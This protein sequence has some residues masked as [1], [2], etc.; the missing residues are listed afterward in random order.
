MHA[1]QAGVPTSYF[2]DQ[3]QGGYPAE[4]SFQHG[5]MEAQTF[6]QQQFEMFE[7]PFEG[8]NYLPEEYYGEEQDFMQMQQGGM[9]QE[10]QQDQA[11]EPN[12]FMSLLESLEARVD[13]MAQ[14][15]HTRAAIQ[16]RARAI[17]DMRMRQQGGG[18]GVTAIEDVT[19]SERFETRVVVPSREVQVQAYKPAYEQEQILPYDSQQ[20]I[21]SRDA[22]S[23]L[24]QENAELWRKMKDQKDVIANLTGAIEGMRDTMQSIGSKDMASVTH[25]GPPT[26]GD[27]EG[28]QSNMY[29]GSL[30]TADF[31]AAGVIGQD[32]RAIGPLERLMKAEAEL[33]G[34]SRLAEDVAQ[35]DMRHQ[36]RNA[37]IMQQAPSDPDAE[38]R[39]LEMELLEERLRQESTAQQ[40]NEER[41]RLYNEIDQARA[42]SVAAERRSPAALLDATAPVHPVGFGREPCLVAPFSREACGVNLLLSEDGYTATRTRGCRQSVAVGS[43]PLQRQAQGWFF[44]VVLGETVTGWVGGLGIGVTSTAPD[45][46]RRVPDKAWRLPS[47]YI[48]GYWGCVFL[49]GRERRTRW[50]SDTLEAGA[51]IGLLVTADSGD[52][53][54]FV[55][56]KPVAFAQGALREKSRLPPVDDMDGGYSGFRGS[57]NE[58]GPLYPVVDVFAATRVVTMSQRASPP[59]P[60]YDV[61]SLS[62]PGSPVS[63]SMR[64]GR[65]IDDTMGSLNDTMGSLKNTASGF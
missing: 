34:N 40:W 42:A 52:L 43:G 11:G 16:K 21:I 59:E 53:V 13:L 26:A 20:A 56:D 54:I 19:Q 2:T 33:Q 7:Q 61:K 10:Q 50:R 9:E 24:V 18:S 35:E 14:M 55:D 44:E 38:R 32:D 30:G 36:L 1:T 22:A 5:S 46:L 27:F 3:M 17:E 62:P 25:G 51:R 65:G 39:R 57:D 8:G 6:E 4:G 12:Q 28:Y 63:V 49:D 31:S 64:N 23:Q 48:V 41:N 15:Q 58:I 60:P 45:Q 37:M 29:P 47:T